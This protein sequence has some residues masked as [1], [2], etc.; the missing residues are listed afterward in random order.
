M[1]DPTA[2]Y[3]PAS[4]KPSFYA[5][6]RSSQMSTRRLKNGKDRNNS[7]PNMLTIEDDPN[8]LKVLL[9]ILTIL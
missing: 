6:R 8:K 1:F 5:S 7:N 9:F 3:K 4:S 2:P